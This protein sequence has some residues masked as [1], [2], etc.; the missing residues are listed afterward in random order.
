MRTLFCSH[1]YRTQ[2]EEKLVLIRNARLA[3]RSL[4]ELTESETE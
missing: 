2:M 3:E 4:T 1:K